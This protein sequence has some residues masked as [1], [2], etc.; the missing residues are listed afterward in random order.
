M[1]KI[2]FESTVPDQY[3]GMFEQ[4]AEGICPGEQL[5]KDLYH[6]LEGA[7]GVLAGGRAFDGAIMDR[8]PNLLII[9][10]TGVGYDTL[11]VDAATERGIAC[12]NAPDAP[13]VS[14]AE[15]A[16][17]LMMT[18]ARAVKQIENELNRMLES[19]TRR[20]LA[21]EYVAW[22]MQH[23][24]LGIIGLGR[25][26]GHVSGIAKAIGMKVAAYDPYIADER[27]A[28]LGVEKAGSLEALL[29]GSDFLTLHLPLN[30]ETTKLMNA[31]RFAQMKAGA[32]FINVAR[33]GH[34]DEAALTAALDSGH[35]FGAG[36]DV[37]DPE[38]PLAGSPLLGRDNVVITPHIAS[39]TVA[40]RPRL[41]THALEQIVQALRG[42]RPPHL[43]NP[44]VW[45]T[46]RARWQ[47]MQMQG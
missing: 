32:V 30:E 13:T 1:Y 34:V 35:L 26:G 25:I 43:L 16:V 31:E 44:E 22:E 14:T 3:R 40:G 5:Q 17:T 18:V 36:L 2:W 20:S 4:I 45:D 41:T 9:A 24:Q 27:F 38:P 37:T 12:V 7:H 33:G 39:S 42:E 11:D 8:A 46:V 6:K 19:G 29:A 15:L 47:G 28:A 10:R 23:T 21:R